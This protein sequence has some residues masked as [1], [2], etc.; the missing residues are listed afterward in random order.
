MLADHDGSEH[1]FEGKVGD[2]AFLI[3]IAIPSLSQ[4]KTVLLTK[5]MRA[6]AVTEALLLWVSSFA[7]AI[8]KSAVVFGIAPHDRGG[9][10]GHLKLAAAH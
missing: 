3:S 2:F 5:R 6:M 1:E 4:L 7:P 8:K 10:L 9:F